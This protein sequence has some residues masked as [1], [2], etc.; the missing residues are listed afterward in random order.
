LI[1]P[2]G[3]FASPD[4]DVRR[5]ALEG[6]LV[7]LGG[8]AALAVVSVV[9][10]MILARLL[11]P[12][13][14]GLLAMVAPLTVLVGTFRELGLTMA[15]VQAPTLE[16]RQSSGLFWLALA[17]NVGVALLLV[18]AAPAAAWFYGEPR[19]VPITI[20][21]A[22]G[23]FFLGLSAQHEALLVRRMQ[24]PALMRNVLRASLAG[25]AVAIGAALLGAGYWALVLQSVVFSGVRTAGIWRA[26][27]WR[28]AWLGWR[29]SRVLEGVR[30]LVSYGVH[31]MG[32][33]A[34]GTVGRNTDRVLVGYYTGATGVGLYDAAYRWAHYPIQHVFP[35][36]YGVAV[37][38][39]SRTQHDPD[40]YRAA[41]RAGFVPV[42]AALLPVLAFMAVEAE[43]AIRVLL[44]ERWLAAAPVFRILCVAYFFN[45]M[46]RL[47]TWLFLS[48][49]NT[50]RQFRWA[51]V[52]TPVM[53]AGAWIGV[54]WGVVGAAWG[55]AAA[56]ILLA[57]PRVAFCL[58][59][60][61]LTWGDFLG[62]VSRPALTSAAA[63]GALLAARRILPLPEGGPAWLAAA[64]LVFAAAYAAAWA[65]TPGGRREA[66]RMLA[67]AGELRRAAFRSPVRDRA[68]RSGAG[69][70]AAAGSAAGREAIAVE[71]AAY[72]EETA[73]EP[74]A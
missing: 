4:G 71:A 66:R 68:P 62:I 33:Q 39:L 40:A 52:Y 19:L 6:G 34:L 50:R 64:A 7:Q 42:L 53:A 54:Q 26:S 1:E 58:A 20:A 48:R 16:T 22:V 61:P 5:R 24:F 14:F 35:P 29:P 72:R 74:L 51:L 41:C 65:T 38:G 70:D 55:V 60:S 37:S 43:S 57:G 3:D 12:A 46:A 17:L 44:G 45:C 11:R 56:T 21:L 18:A 47:T 10:T 32:F 69:P 9:S 30:D 13:D 73:G 31:Y 27:P 49:G 63:A 15:T 36:L 67:L 59:D 2:V 8:Q 25:V 23:V 28:P